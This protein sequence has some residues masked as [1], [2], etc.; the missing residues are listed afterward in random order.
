MRLVVDG[1]VGDA[2]PSLPVGADLHGA[3]NGPPASNVLPSAAN[4]TPVNQT[5]NGT[6]GRVP[7]RR[8]THA[9]ATGPPPL[10]TATPQ[11][12]AQPPTLGGVQAPQAGPH[13]DAEVVT[14]DGVWADVAQQ[15][16]AKKRQLQRKLGSGVA[17]PGATR[18]RPG[19]R[20]AAIGPLLARLAAEGQGG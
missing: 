12:P 18:P 9:V 19:V 13:V 14:A 11:A 6:P 1:G 16:L 7:R 3:Y 15:L 17:T 20:R 4:G 8:P 5:A 2:S 10:P